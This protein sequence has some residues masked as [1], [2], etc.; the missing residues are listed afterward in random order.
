MWIEDRMYH[1]LVLLVQLLII[2]L[3]LIEW[4]YLLGEVVAS[5]KASFS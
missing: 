1:L 3:E 4:I 2:L 5:F